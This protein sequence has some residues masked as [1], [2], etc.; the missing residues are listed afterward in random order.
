MNRRGYL[1]ILPALLGVGAGC[2]E[3]SGSAPR[4][5]WTIGVGT[6]DAGPIKLIINIERPTATTDV[7]PQITTTFK[8]TTSEQIA[9]GPLTTPH[10]SDT[11]TRPGLFLLPTSYPDPK[12]ESPTCLKPRSVADGDSGRRT[13]APDADYKIQYEI[14]LFGDGEAC[15]PHGESRFTGG[16]IRGTDNVPRTRWTFTLSITWAEESGG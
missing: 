8:N 4:Q 12:R 15:R 2:S 1:S 7:T 14:W 6:I 13:L 3:L 9:I 16:I 11:D 10:F 5:L